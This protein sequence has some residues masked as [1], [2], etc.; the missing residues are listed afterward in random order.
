ME[1][2]LVISILAVPVEILMAVEVDQH[3][4]SFREIAVVAGEHQ[5]GC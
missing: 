5:A 1:E 2:I 3:R 4:G